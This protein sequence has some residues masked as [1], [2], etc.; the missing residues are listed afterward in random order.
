MVSRICDAALDPRWSE[1]TAIVI[2]DWLVSGWSV[3][4]GSP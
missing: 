1:P 2:D 3:I 4:S